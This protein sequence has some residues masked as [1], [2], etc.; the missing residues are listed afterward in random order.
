[1]SGVLTLQFTAQTQLDIRRITREMTDM[2]GQI[3]SGAAHSD[4]Q[5]FGGAASRLLNA[6]SMKANAE[7]RQ[8]VLSQLQARFGVQGAALGQVADAS[9]NLAQSIR[10]AIAANDGRGIGTEL[11]LSFASIVSALNESWNGQPLFAGERQGAGPV[12]INTL[13]DLLAALTPDD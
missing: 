5:G 11:D 9:R 3:G 8:S 6:K 12:K 7:A 1:M 4:L 10:E 13:D 2:Q